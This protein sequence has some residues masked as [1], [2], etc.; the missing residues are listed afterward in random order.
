MKVVLPVNPNAGT[1]TSRVRD[2]TRMNPSKFH[3]FKVEEDPQ[4]FIDDGYKVS[5]IMRV[6]MVE[7]AELAAY[8]LKGLAQISYNQWKKRI[9]ED[10]GPHDWR[11]L[12]PLFLIGQTTAR[13][14]GPW[15][16]TATPLQTSSEKLAKSRLTDRPMV[17]RSDHGPWFVTVDPDLLYPTSDMN[18]GRP[19]RTVIRSMVR[20]L[21]NPKPQGGN[22]SGSSL[23]MST[24]TRCGRKHEGK[25]LADID[26]W[27]GCGK[28]GHKM[29]D[30]PMLMAK[31]KEGK[32]APPSGAGSNA[33]KKNQFCA[34]QTRV[35]QDG[36]LDVVTGLLKVVQLDVYNLLDPGATLSMPYMAI[37]FDVLP[38]VLLEPFSLS[39]PVDD[40]IVAKRNKAAET[41]KKRKPEDRQTH[42]A[43][44]RTTMISPNVAVCQ[45]L[46]EKIKSVIEKSS[47]RVTERF[48][49]AVPCHPKYKT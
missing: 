12:R 10:T 2:L 28:S 8:Q 25:C 18:Y 20:R 15:F 21:S 47:H 32:Q 36:S 3:G 43:S 41:T 34:L 5:M 16:T 11:S 6:T 7:N 48:R 49:D 42:W 37:K 22:G 14:G 23:P 19:A 4:E 17:R 33:P 9:T 1:S 44:R 24:C 26:G 13:T 38:D 40:S 39:T 27:F 35:E 45:A 31:G 30:C 46:K 29:R